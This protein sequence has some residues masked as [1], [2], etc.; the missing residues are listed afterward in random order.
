MTSSATTPPAA[1]GAPHGKN[2]PLA[3]EAEAAI[4]MVEAQLSVMWR[5]GRSI[6][7]NLTRKV[8]PELE[9]AAY[10]LLTVLVANG[11]MRLTDLAACIGVG[12][13]S[14]SRQIAFL[15]KIGLVRKEADPS[16]G[17]AQSILLTDLGQARMRSVHAARKMALY[18]RLADWSTEELEQFATLIAKLNHD[19]ETDFGP[20]D[21]VP[22]SAARPR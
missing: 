5:R 1:A 20:G 3:P 12:K 17:R 13:P 10:G 7:H 9:P 18:T 21:I 22:A 11:A 6:N 19:Y 4:E 14:V 15:E 2:A 16:D 8:H